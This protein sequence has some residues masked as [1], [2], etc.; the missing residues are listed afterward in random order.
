M[1]TDD[2]ECVAFFFQR[3]NTNF[4]DK[5]W[6]YSSLKS[7]NKGVPQGCVLRPLV[8]VINDSGVNVGKGPW[9]SPSQCCEWNAPF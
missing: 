5:M 9:K 3:Y 7:V 4:S 1:M 6:F 2:K 8:V